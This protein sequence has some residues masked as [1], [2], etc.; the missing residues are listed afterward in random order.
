MMGTLGINRYLVCLLV[1]LWSCFLSRS[2]GTLTIL[3]TN[4]SY[5]ANDFPLA[6]PE[7]SQTF[8]GRMIPGKVG[9]GCKLLIDPSPFPG[10]FNTTENSDTDV[11]TVLLIDHSKAPSPTCQLAMDVL[12]NNH[13]LAFPVDVFVFVSPYSFPYD[14]GGV[15]EPYFALYTVGLPIKQDLL[16]IGKDTAVAMREIFSSQP[17]PDGLRIVVSDTAG[18]WNRYLHSTGYKFMRWFFMALRVLFLLYAVIHIFLMVRS[19]NFHGVFKP[20][21]YTAIILH[22][23]F[24]MIGPKEVTFTRFDY[25][26]D[27]FAWYAIDNAYFFLLYRWGSVVYQCYRWRWFRIH[28]GMIFAG[29]L[30]SLIWI[31][32]S[33]LDMYDVGREGALATFV[34]VGRFYLTCVY[35]LMLTFFYISLATWVIIH[36]LRLHRVGG[37]VQSLIKLTKLCMFSITGWILIAISLAMTP[38]VWSVPIVSRHITQ[39]MLYHIGSIWVTFTIFWQLSLTGISPFGKLFDRTLSGSSRQTEPSGDRSHTLNS[40]QQSLESNHH[41]QKALDSDKPSFSRPSSGEAYIGMELFCYPP[42]HSSEDQINRLNPPADMSR[43]TLIQH[44]QPWPVGKP[45]GLYIPEP[46]NI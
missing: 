8:Q 5:P 41:Y 11:K 9:P 16:V 17:L 28:F 3:G 25:Y 21:L 1:V 35:L 36:Q 13:D 27:T 14:F 4:Q 30:V 10:V 34:I 33:I 42:P 26:M 19:G 20:L 22:I 23:V 6:L 15:E 18:P 24:Y 38:T 32:T 29:V 39:C 31:V 12:K 44:D 2:D 7:D 43:A 46:P 37:A 40:Q 45:Q